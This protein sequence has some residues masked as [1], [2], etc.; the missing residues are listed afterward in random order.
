MSDFILTDDNYYSQEANLNY[1]SC[2]QFEEFLSCEA[3]AL[4]HV[5]GRWAPS[6]T[7]A[8]FLGKYFHSYF[9]GAKAFD[10][11][12][13]ILTIFQGST[14]PRLQNPEGRKSSENMPRSSRLTT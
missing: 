8:F 7:D 11:F 6:E 13:K 9:E 2:S 4:A 5:Q 10:A 3:A 14:K 12:A 1:F